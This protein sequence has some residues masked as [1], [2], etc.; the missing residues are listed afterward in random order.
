M[1]NVP[2][3]RVNTNVPFPALVRGSGPITIAK[4]NG[5]WIVGFNIASFGS[6]NPPIGNFPTDFVLA[7]D[8]VAQQFIKISLSNL[9]A[10]FTGTKIQRS[11]TATPIVI[12]ATDNQLNCNITSAAACALPAAATRNGA[13]L[14]FKD[15]GGQFA[16]HNL[17]ITPNGAETID[18]AANL[19]LSANR[20]EAT[21]TPFNDGVNTGWMVG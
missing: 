21:L 4:Q 8:S 9:L 12:V 13:P 10:S 3:I 14:T 5:V 2:N 15:V 18:G 1:A 17:T 19:V 20:Q 6:V 11:V 7:W 16:A